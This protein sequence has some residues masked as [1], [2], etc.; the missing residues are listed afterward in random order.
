MEERSIEHYTNRF[1]NLRTGRVGDHLRPHKPVM[2]L[3]VLTLAESGRLPKNRIEFG[4]ELI[5]IFRR[6]FDIVREPGDDCK[7]INPFFFLRGDGFWH[8]RPHPGQEEAYKAMREPGGVGILSQVIANA[9]LDENLF[10]LIAQPGARLLLRDA[11]VS[12]YFPGHQRGLRAL[13]DKEREVG[14]Y[15]DRLEGQAEGMSIREEPSSFAE[16][17]RDTAFRR[18]VTSAYDYRC[19]ACG[20]R[21]VVED[22]ILVDAAHLVPFSIS[23]DDDPRN[24]IALCKNHHWAMD[25]DLIAPGPDEVWHVRGNLEQRIRDHQPILELERMKILLPRELRFYPKKEALAWRLDRLHR[26][27]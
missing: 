13:F 20:M 21:V 5:E 12:R 3:T 6:Y 2:L 8:H 11:L 25:R 10:A 24:G 17:I 7:P 27:E 16:D 4:P 18:T 15:R 22:V 26:A 9:F 23:K 14:L 1:Q 19:A